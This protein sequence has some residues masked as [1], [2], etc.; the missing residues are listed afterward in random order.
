MPERR[1]AR[2]LMTVDTAGSVWTYALQL[3]ALLAGR[4][5]EMTLATIGRPP[6]VIQRRDAAAVA[7]LK[8]RTSEYDSDGAGEWLLDLER[9]VKPDVVHLNDF[10][11]A[12]LPFEAPVMVAA[13]ADSSP[14]DIVAGSAHVTR[15]VTATRARRDALV[16][17][18]GVGHNALIIPYARIADR[19]RR[20]PKEFFVLTQGD[21]AIA[22]IADDL[23]WTMK[24]A[25]ADATIEE[26]TDLMGRASIFAQLRDDDQL[27]LR[28]IE[29][30]LSG[31]ALVLG[32]TDAMR[33][34]WMGAARLVDPSDTVT[35]RDTLL[36]LMTRTS[37]R[38]FLAA[39]ARRRAE[40]FSPELHRDRYYELYVAMMKD[41]RAAPATRPAA[42]P[43]STGSRV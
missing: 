32:D 4:G 2:V 20:Q 41:G 17:L 36:E 6:D 43:S 3:A 33:E 38:E 42:T 21:D 22:A 24:V 28:A 13:H 26:M 29:A 40:L 7:G 19:W 39:A 34:N 25:E 12:A 16:G 31:C 35:L 1:M 8:L 18:Y 27:D 10:A 11:H 37:D 23:P 14:H 5:I 9:E 15:I 30:A